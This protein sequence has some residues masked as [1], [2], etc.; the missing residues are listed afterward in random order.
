MKY[1][2]KPGDVWEWER[3][4]KWFP[5]PDDHSGIELCEPS[6]HRAPMSLSGKQERGRFAQTRA[7]KFKELSRTGLVQ[8]LGS[9]GH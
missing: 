2:L 5:D 6:P 3:R 9:T 1:V 4:V 8:M 7:E